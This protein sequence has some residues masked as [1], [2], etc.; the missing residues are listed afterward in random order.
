M[1]TKQRKQ[2]GYIYTLR[3][4]YIRCDSNKARLNI[5]M[6]QLMLGTLDSY[7]WKD[8][9]RLGRFH[10]YNWTQY[11]AGVDRSGIKEFE[12]TLQS[13]PKLRLV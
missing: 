8:T 3:H 9:L 1:N 13:Y 6:D 4:Q 12:P 10:G 5:R 11:Q 7:D 2:W